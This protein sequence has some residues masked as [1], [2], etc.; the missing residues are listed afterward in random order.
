MAFKR[1][2]FDIENSYMICKGIWHLGEQRILPENIINYGRIIVISYKWEG[3][4]KINRI[5][6]NAGCDKKMMEKF[7]KVISEADEVVTH[8]GDNHDIKWIKTRFLVSGYKSIPDIKSIDTLKI[9]RKFKFPSNKLDE[10]ARYLEKEAGFKI[11]RKLLHSGL[12]MWDDVILYNNK[13]SLKL[14]GEYCDQDVFLLEKIFLFLE[15]FSKPKTHIGR[16]MDGDTCD[17]QYCGSERTNFSRQRVSAAGIVSVA[18]QCKDCHKY[19][20]VSLK[21]Y[22]NRGKKKKKK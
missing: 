15:G 2:F 7:F 5:S 10:I 18:M 17:C 1:L 13:S 12:K 16:F 14:M 4:N 3:T 6:W 20:S 19:F 22:Q 21:A 11:G 9:A 8:N